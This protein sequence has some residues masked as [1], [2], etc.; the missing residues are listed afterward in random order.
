MDLGAPGLASCGLTLNNTGVST[1]NSA[2]EDI[3]ESANDA[4]TGKG[5]SFFTSTQQLQL[6]RQC[7]AAAL[8]LEASAAAT[9]PAL[10]CETASPGI[11]ADFNRCCVGP[12]SVCDSGQS[13][14]QIDASGCIGTLDV[15]NNKFDESTLL[16]FLPQ[17]SANSTN[18]G[19]ATG[20]GFVNP[21][22]NLGPKQ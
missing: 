2:I 21:G 11:T 12:T 7:A 5:N 22:R 3:C 9:N 19:L 10:N 6:I 18:C 1:P 13:G 14:N 16:S 8:N 20:N 17:E 15:F 4:K